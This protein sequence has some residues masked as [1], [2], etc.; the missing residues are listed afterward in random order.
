MQAWRK[1]R[2]GG[3]TVAGCL[4]SFWLFRKVRKHDNNRVPRQRKFERSSALVRADVS[5]CRD[6]FRIESPFYYSPQ[7]HLELF[8]NFE[9]IEW[10]ENRLRGILRSS[11]R[12]EFNFTS[13]N[14]KKKKKRNF[15]F[16]SANNLSGDDC[17]NITIIAS[18]VAP[19]SCKRL[20]EIT[21]RSVNAFVFGQRALRQ[22]LL[23]F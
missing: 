18:A 21:S 11:L 5:A 15:V 7:S 2:E 4:N 20:F 9:I 16:E 13:A 22:R 14:K 3:L 6:K 17:F 19:A 10:K 23:L 12:G 1:T 8:L